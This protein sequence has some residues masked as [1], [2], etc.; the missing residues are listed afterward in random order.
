MLG[1][2]TRLI[3]IIFHFANGLALDT[4]GINRMNKID[5]HHMKPVRADLADNPDV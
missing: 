4:N 3:L 1:S 2:V 5:Y